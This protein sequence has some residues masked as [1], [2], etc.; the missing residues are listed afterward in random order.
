[1]P[2]FLP[3][4]QHLQN[5]HPIVVHFPIAFLLGAAFFYFF[6]GIFRKE[7][8]IVTGFWMLVA[9]FLTLLAAGATGLYAE[10]GVMVS[11]S[12][13][14][15]LL[16]RHERFMI[17]TAV[18]CAVL[19]VWAIIARPLPKKGLLGFAALFLLMLLTLTLGADFGGRMVYEYNAGG[20]ACSQPIE[21]KN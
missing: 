5:I 1:M 16:E 2:S 12:V 21:F 4:A 3:G 8:W 19:I 6:G 7:A 20:Y 14:E 17:V 13:R 15:H 10:S 9:G 18:L 11:R